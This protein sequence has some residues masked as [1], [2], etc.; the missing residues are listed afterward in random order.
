M[1]QNGVI[2]FINTSREINH[3][4]YSFGIELNLAPQ[5]HSPPGLW[6]LVLW[7]EIEVNSKAAKH[8]V[9]LIGCVDA[10]EITSLTYLHDYH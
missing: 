3:V 7:G 8:M 9:H 4:L 2:H 5:H 10:V 1:G 6:P